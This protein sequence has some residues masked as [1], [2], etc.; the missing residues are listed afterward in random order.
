MQILGLGWFYCGFRVE[1]ITR[2]GITVVADGREQTISLD[3]VD[4]DFCE[5]TLNVEA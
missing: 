3:K 4:A 2:N 5:R 1:S